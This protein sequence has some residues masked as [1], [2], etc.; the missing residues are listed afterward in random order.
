MLID[1]TFNCRTVDVLLGQTIEVR[2]KEN[3][4]TGFRWQLTSDGGPACVVND[5]EFTT[6]SGPPGRGGE[7]TWRFKVV[8]VGDGDIELAY[9]RRWESSPEAG[10]TFKI[11]VKVGS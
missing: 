9:R 4:T 5:D 6:A 1:E 7:H 2:L 3:P 8:G 10:K 11:H